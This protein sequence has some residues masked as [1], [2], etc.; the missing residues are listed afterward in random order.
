MKYEKQWAPR[1]RGPHCL[2]PCCTFTPASRCRFTPALTDYRTLANEPAIARL[3]L[4]DEDDK[5]QV[6][7]IA[8]A[9]APAGLLS[10]I[11]VAS[12]LSP[13]GRLAATP[14]GR[15]VDIPLPGGGKYFHVYE[16]A[17][18]RPIKVNAEWDATNTVL[19]SEDRGP[20]TIFSLRAVLASML[21]REDD[22]DLLETLLRSDVQKKNSVEGITRS[23]ITKMGLRDQPILDEFQDEIFRLPLDTHL[24]IMGPPGTGKTTT[25]IKRLAQKINLENLTDAERRGVERSHA[26]VENHLTSWLAFTPT[27]LLRQ[28]VKEAF[29][30]ERIAAPDENI[31]TWDDQRLALARN[32]FGI[33]RT[34]TRSGAVLRNDLSNLQLRAIHNQVEWFQHFD[35]WQR[36]D[37][38]ADLQRQAEILSLAPDPESLAFAQKAQLITGTLSQSNLVAAIAG[39]DDISAQAVSLATRLRSS[40]VSTL[41]A[42]FSILLKKDRSLLDSL[43]AFLV[44]LDEEQ[45]EEEEDESDIED[46][47]VAHPRPRTREDAFEAYIRVVRA[48]ASA[49]INKRTLAGRTRNGRILQWLGERVPEEDKI[50]A[51]GEQQKQVSA[52]RRFT[53]PVRAYSDGLTARYRRYRRDQLAT[54]QWYHKSSFASNELGVLEVDLLLYSTMSYAHSLLR[55]KGLS[56]RLE[57]RNVSLLSNLTSLLRNQIL[58]DEVTDFAPLQLACMAQLCD[59][60][61][62]SFLAC[63]DFNQR[64]TSW[65]SRTVEDL[66]WVYPDLN[67]RGVNITYRHSRQLREFTEKLLTTMGVPQEPAQLPD[68]VDNEGVSPALKLSASGTVL[69]DWLARRIKEIETMIGSLPSIAVLVNSE[70]EVQPIA[71]GLTEALRPENIRCTAC[72]G[73]Q[74]K[75]QDSDVRVF[76]IQHIKGLEFEAV[77]FLGVDVLASQAEDLFDKY[78]YVGTTRAAVYLGLTCAGPSLPPK[79]VGLKDQFVEAWSS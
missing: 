35:R 75:G 72:P 10:N 15:E 56:A 14:V 24:A 79:M 70:E 26:G 34:T 30:Q 16:R 66:R 65:G 38:Q 77:F 28:Y 6:L 44:T 64:V 76:D 61:V 43:L 60:E 22:Q 25:L 13:M 52:L 63:G 45:H 23:V 9:S 20:K 2:R 7:F 17:K 47:D 53:N 29:A 36:E 59:P 71:R 37:F 31:K 67:I 73:G 46:E 40:I 18:I 8:R 39:L 21:Y 4:K 57:S 68:I 32:S 54:G 74:V 51:L 55:D 1:Y 27:E 50:L 78:L 19:E 33:L 58:I 62:N 69:M 12:Y 5:T 11:K 41:R 42:E 3:V 49:K 48:F